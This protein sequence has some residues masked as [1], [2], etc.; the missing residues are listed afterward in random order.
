MG[1][2][3]DPCEC[4]SVNEWA[5]YTPAEAPNELTADTAFVKDGIQIGNGVIV[6]TGEE[7]TA[8]T[9]YVYFESSEPTSNIIEVSGATV[10][11][12]LGE[13]DSVTGVEIVATTDAFAQL[14]APAK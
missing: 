11:V 6:L 5:G 3:K 2:G 4:G 13:Y 14:Y 1:C 7:G 8:Y 12:D 10:Y 9:I